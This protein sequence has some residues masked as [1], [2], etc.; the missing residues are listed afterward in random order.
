MLRAGFGLLPAARQDYG[1]CR[2]AAEHSCDVLL[3]RTTTC[4][5]SGLRIYPGRGIQFIRVDG[6]VAVKVFSLT[7]LQYVVLLETG[8][9]I[10]RLAE[11]GHCYAG[12]TGSKAVGGAYATLYAKADAPLGMHH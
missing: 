11:P 5:F 10:A 8:A 12:P 6:Q 3:L 4:R 2:L 7:P 9:V 1:L